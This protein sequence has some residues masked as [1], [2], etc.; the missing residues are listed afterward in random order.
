MGREFKIINWCDPCQR[1]GNQV[2]ADGDP[3]I[4]TVGARKS[5][6]PKELMFCEVHRKEVMGPLLA[7]LEFAPNYN[8]EATVLPAVV[9]AASAPK[10]NT[11]VSSTPASGAAEGFMGKFLAVEEYP[12]GVPTP[13]V[14]GQE[15]VWSCPEADCKDDPKTSWSN[16]DRA[17]PFQSLRLHMR[18]LHG[19][20]I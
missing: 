16:K 20:D 10:A 12:E 15:Q 4:V 2:E 11:G 14:N 18:Q 3:F 8:L 19:W 5:D 1:E 13:T 6:R 9:K 17:R 7:E